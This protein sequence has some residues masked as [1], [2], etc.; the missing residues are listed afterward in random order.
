MISGITVIN[1]NR[2]CTCT[3]FVLKCM[4]LI[5]REEISQ[6]NVKHAGYTSSSQFWDCIHAYSN[7]CSK[8]FGNSVFK[9][10]RSNKK[11][12]GIIEKEQVWDSIKQVVAE[13]QHRDIDCI[14]SVSEHNL[15]CDTTNY[16]SKEL[17]Q[18]NTLF[19]SQSRPMKS[20]FDLWIN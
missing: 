6:R 2:W 1:K 3:C 20:L 9:T 4:V 5:D 13:T 19:V 16:P 18:L 8:Q 17:G 7:F 12:R 15:L 10:N 11:H 14:L